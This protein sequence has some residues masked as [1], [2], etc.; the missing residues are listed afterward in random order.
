MP[1]DLR[2]FIKKHLVYHEPVEYS[3]TGT[4]LLELVEL[5]KTTLCRETEANALIEVPTP[6]K[7]VGDLH[8]AFFDLQRY[9]FAIGMPGKHRYLFLGGKRYISDIN[10]VF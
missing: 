2:A 5:A 3:K 1:L 10:F 7:I 9:F 6:V 8:G 4:E